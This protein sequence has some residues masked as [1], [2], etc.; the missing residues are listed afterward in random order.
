M[1]LA[2]QS[3]AQSPQFY[4]YCGSKSSKYLVK[5]KS[6]GLLHRSNPD[7]AFKLEAIETSHWSL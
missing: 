7:M 3:E 1:T 6:A 5:W 2:P 4:H